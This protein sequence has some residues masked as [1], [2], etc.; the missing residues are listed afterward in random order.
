MMNS[1]NIFENRDDCKSLFQRKTLTLK[2][3][4]RC[5]WPPEIM[6][7]LVKCTAASAPLK[8]QYAL[9][10]NKYLSNTFYIRNSWL[11]MIF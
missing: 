2:I 11:Q 7:V 8:Y 4:D 3:L 5:I 6:I 1:L 9:N 10:R